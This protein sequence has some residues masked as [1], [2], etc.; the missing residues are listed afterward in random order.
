MHSF[1]LTTAH[2]AS[3]IAV[4]GLLVGSAL[5]G[6]YALSPRVAP[7]AD[8]NAPSPL[9]SV[10]PPPHFKAH[11]KLTQWRAPLLIGVDVFDANGR[12]VGKVEDV[13][14]DHDGFVQTVVIRV[15]GILGVGGKSV[16]V[17]FSAMQWRMNERPASLIEASASAAEKPPSGVKPPTRVEVAE[18]AQGHPDKAGVT[19]TL[20]QL[21]AAPAF[22]Y[23]SGGEPDVPDFGAMNDGESPIS[24]YR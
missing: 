6:S 9:V 23:A 13:L 7:A 21:Q 22:A 17:P 19:P 1:R 16:A 4:F 2:S 18:A 20:A 24:P 12:P 15:G 5:A 3:R 10:A 8:G 14:M 11:Q